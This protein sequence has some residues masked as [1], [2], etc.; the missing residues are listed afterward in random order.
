MPPKPLPTPLIT[1]L[2]THSTAAAPLTAPSEMS[3]ATPSERWHFMIG[4]RALI[5]IA[6]PATRPCLRMDLSRVFRLAPKAWRWSLEKEGGVERWAGAGA[7]RR[8]ARPPLIFFSLP[9]PSPGKPGRRIREL[10]RRAQDDDV[11]V[12]AGQSEAGR[13]GAKQDGARRRPERGRGAPYGVH[14]SAHGNDRGLRRVGGGW[15]GGGK[16]ARRR[17][18]PARQR[19]GQPQIRRTWL[20]DAARANSSTS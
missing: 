11:Q 12:G 16:R 4:T 8:V 1:C 2:C 19:G 17:A 13:L 6:L 15:V 5:T 7:P 9:L 18:G 3:A 14:G 20:G 10:V